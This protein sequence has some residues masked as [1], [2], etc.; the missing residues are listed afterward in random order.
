[1][2][3]F[4]INIFHAWQYIPGVFYFPALQRLLESV[5]TRTEAFDTFICETW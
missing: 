3:N 4:S 2:V 1:M 5:D